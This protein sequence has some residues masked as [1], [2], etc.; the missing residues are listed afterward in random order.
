MDNA[1]DKILLLAHP[2]HP[3]VDGRW[4]ELNFK[5]CWGVPFT[6]FL[7][8]GTIPSTKFLLDGT[9]PSTKFLLDSTVLATNSDLILI[10]KYLILVLYI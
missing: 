1:L 10:E 5:V 6:K 7:L 3:R 4:L 9:V 8:D 2:H